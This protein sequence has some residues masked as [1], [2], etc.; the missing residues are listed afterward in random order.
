[1]GC[2]SEAS[3]HLRITLVQLTLRTNKSL[4]A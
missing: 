4:P 3:A 1:L 2:P